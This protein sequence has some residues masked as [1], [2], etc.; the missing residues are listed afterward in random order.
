MSNIHG[1]I[2]RVR[3]DWY[4]KL[5]YVILGVLKLY[6]TLAEFDRFAGALGLLTAE[7]V[8]LTFIYPNMKV[9]ARLGT[10]T[11]NKYIRSGARVC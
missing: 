5:H 7:V 9:S 10:F 8:E 11:A 4:D 3:K 1:E 6:R 2:K